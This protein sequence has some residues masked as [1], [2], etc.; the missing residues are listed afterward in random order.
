[1]GSIVVRGVLGV[2]MERPSLWRR[3]AGK[4]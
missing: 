3:L 4:G 1:V 2:K